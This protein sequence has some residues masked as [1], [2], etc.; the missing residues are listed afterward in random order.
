LLDILVEEGQKHSILT[1]TPYFPE[2]IHLKLG[3]FDAEL[4]F[5]SNTDRWS[6]C[7]EEI[8]ES[9]VHITD[10][11]HVPRFRDERSK[12]VGHVRNFFFATCFPDCHPIKWTIKIKIEDHFHKVV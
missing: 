8:S 10:F 7:Q 4:N 9:P 2:T 12:F 6:E 3:P 1:E 11:I 5:A